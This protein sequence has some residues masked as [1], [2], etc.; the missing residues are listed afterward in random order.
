MAT[1]MLEKTNGSSAVQKATARPPGAFARDPFGTLATMRQL[2]DSFFNDTPFPVLGAE[3]EPPVNLY[4]KDG[5]YTLECAV[6]GY[7]K[8]DLTVEVRGDRAT[9]SGAYSREKNEEK[10][11]YHRHEA[12]QSSFTRTIALPQQIDPD[13]V[14][15]KLEHGMLR[16][17]LNPTTSIK[18]KT[19]PVLE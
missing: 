13:K 15:A 8:E 7:K 16:V 11:H 19:I 18:H 4:E 6:P 1:Q 12:V 3:L 9:I 5:T 17:T 2:M 10:N 14:E